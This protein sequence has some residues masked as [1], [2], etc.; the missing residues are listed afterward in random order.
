[1]IALQKGLEFRGDTGFVMGVWGGSRGEGSG[2]FGIGVEGFLC[3]FGGKGG[4]GKLAAIGIFH[5]FRLGQT[6]AGH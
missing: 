5:E 1:M 6:A 2:E 4:S 3:G